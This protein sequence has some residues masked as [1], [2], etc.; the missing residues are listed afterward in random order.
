[1]KKI[2]L[3][4]AL[5]F[6]IIS[7]IEEVD[8]AIGSVESTRDILIIEATLTDELKN[9]RILITRMDTLIDLAIDSVFSPF[10]PI[11]DID[12]DLVR[13]EENATVTVVDDSGS[14]YM[15]IESEPGIYVSSEPFAAR[16]EVN[17]SLKVTTADGRGYSSSA[18]SIE[19]TSDINSFY[20]QK[21]IS[22]TGA[23]GIG[24][25]VSSQPSAGRVNKLRYTYDE[26]YKIVAPFW[27]SKDFKLTNYDPCALPVPTY[28]LEIIEREEEQQTCYGNTLSNTIIQVG[29]NDEVDSGLQDF[30]V[31]FIN[32][33]N[34]ILSHR[35]SIEVT[36][37]V[38]GSESF[39][40]YEQLN[41]F[42]QQ[43]NIFSQ[44]Q[45]GFLEGNLSADNGNTG[46]IMGFFDVVSVSKERLFFNYTDFYPEEPL[47]PYVFNC[48]ETSAPESHL[49]YCYSGPPIPDT[50]PQSVIERVN[51]GLISFV[52]NNDGVAVGQECPGP[53]VFV[54]RICGDCTLLGSNV[55]PEFWT[56]E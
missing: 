32:K 8:L 28:D 20:A 19:G 6:S 47:P 14:D 3:S 51:L 52:A 44:V 35:Y 36:Q 29:Q 27:S 56:E 25:F 23:E 15:F 49:S 5:L 9:Q 21:T 18:M 2:I 54:V 55:A 16:L 30:R 7:C 42:S 10:V 22:G 1:M 24:I 46:T 39:G 45:P 31:R 43:G 48:N 12:R 4:I 26:T 37:M 50:C 17:Y 11:R 33:D 40:F 41:N 38:A 53:H 34:F 13:Y